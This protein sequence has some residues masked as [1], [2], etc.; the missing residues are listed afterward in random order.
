MKI[1]QRMYS[2]TLFDSPC[3]AIIVFTF[4]LLVAFD[5][6]LNRS[7]IQFYAILQEQSIRSCGVIIAT[8]IVA[9]SGRTFI[10]TY[11]VNIYDVSGIRLSLSMSTFNSIIWDSL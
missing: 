9:P 4:I 1:V 11:L 5:T 8:V 10:L 7:D 3:T 6:A 2:D